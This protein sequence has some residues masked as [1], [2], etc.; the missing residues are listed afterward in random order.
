MAGSVAPTKA[1]PTIPAISTPGVAAPSSPTVAAVDEASPVQEPA[2]SIVL[3]TLVIS[4]TNPSSS[5][6]ASS[7]KRPAGPRSSK[8]DTVPSSATSDQPS[9][10]TGTS[11]SPK[12]ATAPALRS[13]LTTR[14]STPNTDLPVL[15]SASRT[16][17][18][19]NSL[20]SSSIGQSPATSVSAGVKAAIAL[21]VI[22]FISIVV[23]TAS[24]LWLRRR[25]ERNPPESPSRDD[26]TVGRFELATESSKPN[27]RRGSCEK[28][29]GELESP[30]PAGG[31]YGSFLSAEKPA[32]RP[33]GFSRRRGR[34]ELDG[35]WRPPEMQGRNFHKMSAP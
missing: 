15:A 23:M 28:S 33:W 16:A 3:K 10:A 22:I 5:A 32:W 26:K 6:Q 19:L 11:K 4:V 29:T 24:L 9:H 35:G 8:P 20:V 31:R 17:T 18:V 1:A 7:G 27:T 12:V 2:T 34:Q 25:K 30:H 21:G 14:A 13:T